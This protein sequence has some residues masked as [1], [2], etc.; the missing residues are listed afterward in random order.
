MSE[1]PW[2]APDHKI[3]ARQPT[4]RE[5]A[6]TMT[7]NGHT[8]RCE[9]RSHGEYGWETQFFRNDAL[10]Y[11]ERFTLRSHAEQLASDK[12]HELEVR[13]WNAGRGKAIV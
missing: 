12:R 7:K 2:F 3:P 11:G 8:V 13:G 9:F 4:P 10:L 5:L 1:K 6:W